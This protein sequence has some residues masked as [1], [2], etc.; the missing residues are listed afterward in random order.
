MDRS[1]IQLLKINQNLATKPF[2]CGDSDLN[3]FLRND[4]W[5]YFEERMAVT[6]ILTY[7]ENIVAYYCLLNDKVAF[8]TTQEK[9]RPFWNQFNR[10]NKIP[11]SK[12]RQNYPAVKLGRLAV[13]SQFKDQ[14]LGRFILN[15]I[16]QTLLQN[17]DIGCRFLTV[18]A[19]QS[20]LDFYLK[21][22]FRHISLLDE[23]EDTRL[24]YYDLKEN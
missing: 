11:N 9:E 6:Y 23:E 8:D 17:T 5:H 18:D 2:D 4:A 20:A 21:N 15:G 7:E 22:E 19:Y 1:Q 16:K 12:R 14:G 13:S 10:K 24:M 3:A